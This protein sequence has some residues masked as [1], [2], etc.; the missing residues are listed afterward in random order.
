MGMRNSKFTTVFTSVEAGNRKRLALVGKKSSFPKKKNLSKNIQI[1]FISDFCTNEYFHHYFLYFAVLFYLIF[2]SI[3]Q[4]MS[5][6]T[7]NRTLQEEK[8]KTG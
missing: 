6:T 1:S 3:G 7:L 4:F 8:Y 5:L 2:F